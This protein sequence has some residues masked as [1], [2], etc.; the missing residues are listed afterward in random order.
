VYY[1]PRCTGNCAAVIPFKISTCLRIHTAKLYRR[2]GGGL[3]SV[4]SWVS[5][6]TCRCNHIERVCGTH[7]LGCWFPYHSCD[8]VYFLF[9]H[10]LTVSFSGCVE[11]CLKIGECGRDANVV[12]RSNF[13]LGTPKQLLAWKFWLM[14]VTVI[15]VCKDS[16][17]RNW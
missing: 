8:V 15:A 9:T 14:V 10:I 4:R 13:L 3:E 11:W 5:W 2:W 16:S 1:L 7:R 6:F 17:Y 12:F